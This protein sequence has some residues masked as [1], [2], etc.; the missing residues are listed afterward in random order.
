MSPRQVLSLLASCGLLALT[1]PAEAQWPVT[2][3]AA[4]T[5]R[6]VIWIQEAAR[7]VQSLSNQA[8]QIEQT[9]NVIVNQVRQIENQVKNLQRLPKGLNFMDDIR[10]YSGQITGILSTA[11]ALSFQLDQATKDFERL[12]KDTQTLLSP[13]QLL[14]TRQQ[15]LAGRR[16]MAGMAVQVQ[17]IQTNMTDVYTRLCNLLSGSFAAIGNLDSQQIAAQQRGLQAYQTQQTQAMAATIQRL[18]AMHQAEE[19][20]LEQQRLLALQGA[21]GRVETTVA[22]QGKLPDPHW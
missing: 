4:L 5:Q 8:Q 10:L 2:D 6:T 18:E 21:M 13:Q 17:S 9:Y 14:Q 15:M 11:N 19:V 12:Y 3:A 20:W 7:W 1:P 16:E 22:P